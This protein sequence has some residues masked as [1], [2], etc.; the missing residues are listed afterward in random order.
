MKLKIALILLAVGLVAGYLLLKTNNRTSAP[1]ATSQTNP[2]DDVSVIRQFM[3]K[4]DLELSSVGTDLPTQYFRVGKVTKI[5]T[6]ENMD[7]VDGWVRQVNVYD[8]KDL[9]NGTCSVYE[10]NLDA[11]N[12]KLTA[13][14][15]RGLK[16]SE[17]ADYKNNGTTCSADTD[18]KQKLSK[19]DAETIAMDYLKRGVSNFDQI[20]NQFV[21]SEQYNGESHE[22][23]WE[24]KKYKLPEGLSSRPYQYPIIRISVYSNGEIQ[25]WNTTPLF[26]N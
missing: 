19:A 15:I 5:G 18:N 9:V 13:V 6:G 8:Q 10:Y 1:I 17:I 20:K 21:Y 14:I 22:W 24:D 7:K 25:Y 3:G 16:P 2:T 23:L 4:S 11:R 12:H 26:E